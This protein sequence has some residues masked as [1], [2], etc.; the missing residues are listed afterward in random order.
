MGIKSFWVL[1]SIIAFGG[2]FGIPGMIIGA[3]V[4]ALLYGY[5][6]NK[7]NALLIEKDLPT[8]TSLYTDLTAVNKT[9]NK[10]NYKDE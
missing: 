2:I 6:K 10:L 7:L 5:V 4:F 9:T 8:E 3:P 1:F